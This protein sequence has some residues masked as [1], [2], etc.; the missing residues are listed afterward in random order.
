MR[1]TF[2]LSLTFYSVLPQ[3]NSLFLPSCVYG[4]FVKLFLH[5]PDN[6]DSPSSSLISESTSHND[7]L[8][9]KIADIEQTHYSSGSSLIFEFHSDWRSG[10][11]TGFR[12]TFRF[13]SKRKKTIYIYSFFSLF[14]ILSLSLPL[15]LSFSYPSNC[16]SI[17]YTFSSLLNTFSHSSSLALL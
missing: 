6:P 2:L 10:N 4:D 9:G 1:I 15:F 16:S 17:P 8:C 11:N 7:V 13:L 3:S 5:I 14:L 12:G